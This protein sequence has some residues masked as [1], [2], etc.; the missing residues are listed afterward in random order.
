MSFRHVLVTGGTGYVGSLLVPQLIDLGY[1]VTVYDINFF[2]DAKLFKP[3]SRN[4][5]PTLPASSKDCVMVPTSLACR[6]FN[7]AMQ[8]I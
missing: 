2:G 4:S 7:C 1:K 6:D 3:L 5:L 8:R